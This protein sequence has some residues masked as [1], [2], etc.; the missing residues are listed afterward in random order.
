LR[1]CKWIIYLLKLKKKEEKDR[2]LVR[3]FWI[4]WKKHLQ[5]LGLEV[6]A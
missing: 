2:Q 1:S 6:S 3:G 4:F 5:D